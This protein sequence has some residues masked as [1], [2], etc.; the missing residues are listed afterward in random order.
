MEDTADR[1]T[2]LP[3]SA[4]G[5]RLQPVL[6]SRTRPL[7]ASLADSGLESLL[8]AARKR[9]RRAWYAPAASMLVIAFACQSPPQRSQACL[10]EQRAI[11]ELVRRGAADEARPRIRAY[12]EQCRGD[13]TY[14][15]DRWERSLE[16]QRRHQEQVEQ[17]RAPA[18]QD[19]TQRALSE[20]LRWSA[21][22]REA[23]DKSLGETAC[24]PPTSDAF[25]LC[26]SRIQSGDSVHWLHHWRL[27][28][29]IFK[30]ETR[31]NGPLHCTHLGQHRQVA[32]WTA[33]GVARE[34][35]E[36]LEHGLH[37]TQVLIENH[38]DHS[39]VHVFSKS[40]PGKDAAFRERLQR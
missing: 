16:R 26:A 3:H 13:S 7:M 30:F 2:R 39:V 29:S 21:S 31:L 5:R 36:P 33:A 1:Q 32:R 34:L 10:D 38:S 28:P 15:I 9:G 40:Y 14:D 18:R 37:G 6:Q 35:C 4:A 22:L 23:H 25:G 12:A 20:F 27:D 11:S 24:E 17:R 19:A 8:R